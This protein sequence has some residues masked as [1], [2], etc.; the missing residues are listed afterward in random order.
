VDPLYYAIV[1]FLIGLLLLLIDLF[2]PTGG[3]LIVCGA[4]C[5]ALSVFFAF[6]SSTNTGLIFLLMV[7]GAI[8]VLSYFFLKAWPHT[9]VGKRV[10]LAP[11]KQPEVSKND[12]LRSLIGTVV[13]NRW[14][15][16]PTGQIQIGH[17]RYNAMSFDGKIIEVQARVKVIDIHE[18]L[19]VVSQT[20]EPLSDPNS[21]STKVA[22]AHQPVDP[23]DIS[24]EELGLERLDEK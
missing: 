20:T 3:I 12:E 14:A 5:A 24:A 11:P 9:P 13:V 19:L 2:V 6:R 21:V 17:R 8:P 22:E 15:L 4:C 10:T 7:L 1:L 23:L 18:R 16:I